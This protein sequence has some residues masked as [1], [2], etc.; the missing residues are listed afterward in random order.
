M[1]SDLPYHYQGE[2]TGERQR[3]GAAEIVQRQA[4]VLDPRVQT[5]GYLN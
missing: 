2:V 3:F 4:T 1:H 5:G